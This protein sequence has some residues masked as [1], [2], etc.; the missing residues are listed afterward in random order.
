MHFHTIRK[1]VLISETK[2]SLSTYLD[3]S[4]ILLG[5]A[6]VAPHPTHKQRSMGRKEEVLM[7]GG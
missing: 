7:G 4:K 6:G 2:R 1:H 3:W 5:V